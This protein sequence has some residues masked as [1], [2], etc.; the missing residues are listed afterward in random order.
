MFDEVGAFPNNLLSLS[1]MLMLTT[2]TQ[3][4]VLQTEFSTRMDHM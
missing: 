1:S 4:V 3:I 2:T